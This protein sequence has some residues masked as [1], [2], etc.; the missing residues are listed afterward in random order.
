MNWLPWK[1]DFGQLQVCDTS[2]LSGGEN[3]Q[4][5]PTFLFT[6]L[7]F[8]FLLFLCASLSVGYEGKGVVD[9][10]VKE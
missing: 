7:L 8:S 3:N 4:P 6:F 9:R 5:S 1:G 10:R 2:G